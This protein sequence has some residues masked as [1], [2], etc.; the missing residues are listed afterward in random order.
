MR[1]LIREKNDDKRKERYRM[2]RERKKTV[3]NEQ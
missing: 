3:Q 1:K 2:K